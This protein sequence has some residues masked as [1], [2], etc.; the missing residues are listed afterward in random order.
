MYIYGNTYVNGSLSQVQR[1]GKRHS[2]IVFL[3]CQ[4][5]Q[6]II[7]FAEIE[8]MYYQIK[9]IGSCLSKYS[10][11]FKQNRSTFKLRGT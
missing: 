10:I 11:K 7:I 5:H 8:I 3:H 2:L 9:I 1:L 6:L 4:V